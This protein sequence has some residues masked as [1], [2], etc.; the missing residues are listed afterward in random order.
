M[1]YEL[2]KRILERSSELAEEAE[3]KA[4]ELAE[5]NHGFTMVFD[6]A[7]MDALSSVAE[8]SGVAVKT[9]L[10]LAKNMDH[11][12][13]VLVSNTTL[14]QM[15]DIAPNNISRSMIILREKGLIF[16]LRTGG[17]NLH[18]INPEVAWRSTET[19]KKYALFHTRV[20]V[21]TRELEEG[22][23]SAKEKREATAEGMRIKSV[24][25]KVLVP[26]KQREFA[27]PV[28]PE[29]A[30]EGNLTPE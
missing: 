15:L 9:F 29:P 30:I 1:D 2:P 20:I 24:R 12:G 21:P 26:K 14:A 4:K 25:A 13:S 16:T 18:C 11:Q 28:G 27:P 22:I 7:G 5:K 19:G 23:Q 3:E 17:G 6:G 10:W 8:K